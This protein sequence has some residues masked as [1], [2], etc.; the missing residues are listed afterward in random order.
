MVPPLLPRTR[1]VVTNLTQS[2]TGTVAHIMIAPMTA[3]VG[4]STVE[5][6]PHITLSSFPLEFE[7]CHTLKVMLKVSSLI[8]LKVTLKVM[9]PQMLTFTIKK[10]FPFAVQESSSSLSLI[11]VLSPFTKILLSKVKVTNPQTLQIT[12]STL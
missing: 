7:V 5:M 6:V 8:T 2:R 3:T 4:I 9:L 10:A 1:K 12:T 11:A